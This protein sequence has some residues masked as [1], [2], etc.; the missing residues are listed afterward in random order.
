[1][2]ALESLSLN[3]VE[4]CSTTATRFPFDAPSA[5]RTLALADVSVSETNL[6]VLFQWAISSTHLESVTFQ[7]CE[8]IG[9][10]MP[11]VTT[12][13]QRCIGA[14]VRCMRLEN[15][16]MN[17]RHVSTLAKALQGTQVRIPFELDLSNNPFLIAGTQ[18]LLKALATCTNVSVKL[19]S[20][21]ES[22]LQDTERVYLVKARAAGVTIDVCDEDVYIHS[23]RALNA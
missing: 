14:G 18:A 7:C 1:M 9:S 20:A 6:D 23:P 17:T 4:L 11:Y 19:P 16:G 5:L 3:T 22:P 13:V 15:C 12:T 10:R 21:L 2:S 8:W